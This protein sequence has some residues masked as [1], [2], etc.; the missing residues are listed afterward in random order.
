MHEEVIRKLF[1]FTA[2]KI[3]LWLDKDLGNSSIL[4]QFG[5]N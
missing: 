1:V 5:F 2:S 3:I 4:N